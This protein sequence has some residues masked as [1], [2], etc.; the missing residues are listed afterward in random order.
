M[1]ASLKQEVEALLSRTTF[2]LSNRSVVDGASAFPQAPA[3]IT[4]KA[5]NVRKS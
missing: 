2:L 4:F 1:D 5:Q 3:T